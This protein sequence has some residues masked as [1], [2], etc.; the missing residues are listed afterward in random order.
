MILPFISFREV[1]ANSPK[2]KCLIFRLV[3]NKRFSIF[4]YFILFL[5]LW[6]CF[7]GWHVEMPFVKIY[8]TKLAFLS[9]AYLV[10]F[11]SECLKLLRQKK[12]AAESFNNG[13]WK[14]KMQSSPLRRV[15]WETFYFW[16]FSTSINQSLSGMAFVILL[17]LYWI[18]TPWYKAWISASRGCGAL[19]D[20]E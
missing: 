15:Q 12:D 18:I 14:T 17:D 9:K 19:I 13:W 6:L 7:F 20:P 5:F 8:L 2:M 10:P 4:F 11:F 1:G 16:R 3:K